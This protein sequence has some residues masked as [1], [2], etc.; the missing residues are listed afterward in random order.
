LGP[1]VPYFSIIAGRHLGFSKEHFAPT[2]AEDKV[3]LVGRSADDF[4]DH[5]RE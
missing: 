1:G 5:V 2:S 4:L 3:P